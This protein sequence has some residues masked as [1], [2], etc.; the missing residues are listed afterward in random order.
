MHCFG[1]LWSERRIHWHGKRDPGSMTLAMSP[2]AGQR[3]FWVLFR[4]T[5]CRDGG[6]AGLTGED[7][8]E[9]IALR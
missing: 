4:L 2:L 5:G 1:T 9:L 3:R 6:I 8:Q 7:F